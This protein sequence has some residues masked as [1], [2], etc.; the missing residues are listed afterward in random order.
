MARTIF[1]KLYDL[2]DGMR[3]VGTGHMALAELQPPVPGTHRWDRKA[4]DLAWDPL[5]GIATAE[6]DASYAAMAA[7]RASRGR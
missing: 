5:S 4:V 6:V 1:P 7:W 3:L 2:I